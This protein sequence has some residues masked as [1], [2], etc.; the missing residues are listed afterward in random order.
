M[1]QGRAA[2]TG[3]ARN[4]GRKV[5]GKLSVDRLL[6][7]LL[8]FL[9]LSFSCFSCFSSCSSS[10]CYFS[11]SA[12]RAR[13][14]YLPQFLLGHLAAW[15]LSI[16]DLLY[17]K[18][19]SLMKH[20]RPVSQPLLPSSTPACG[21][22]VSALVLP[23]WRLPL[24]VVVTQAFSNLALVGLAYGLLYFAWMHVN[25]RLCGAPRTY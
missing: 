10:S 3:A 9:L 6:L 2:G 4:S 22:D 5:Q 15:P 13:W 1:A 17:I 18:D 23:S 24:C 14:H 21:S 20:F 16:I 25:H 11:P 8:Q 12:V 7:F 19:M